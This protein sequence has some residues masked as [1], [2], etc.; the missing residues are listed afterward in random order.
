[1]HYSG[2][3]R[4]KRRE[5]LRAHLLSV[6]DVEALTV[7]HEHSLL[8][9]GRPRCGHTTLTEKERN[10]ARASPKT[11]NREKAEPQSASSA[12]RGA[13]T[14]S[15]R[16]G[17][18]TGGEGG[19]GARRTTCTGTPSPEILPAVATSEVAG[20]TSFAGSPVHISSPSSKEMRNFLHPAHVGTKSRVRRASQNDRD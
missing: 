1:M 14:A 17:G 4:V 3:S 2:C 5:M 15:D 8:C 10:S 9:H 20:R 13:W 6:A 7:L 19:G 18:R 11:G 16:E 12:T